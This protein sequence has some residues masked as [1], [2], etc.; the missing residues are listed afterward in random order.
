[1]RRHRVTA[2]SRS[3]DL[4]QYQ[5]FASCTQPG[6]RAAKARAILQGFDVANHD[7][8]AIIVGKIFE[9]VG[10]AQVS[11]VAGRDDM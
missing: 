8:G 9:K 11:F 1:M 10:K 3:A 6:G 7:I 4:D 5:R 2:S